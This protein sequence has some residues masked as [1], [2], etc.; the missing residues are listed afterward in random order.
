MGITLPKR[1][2]GAAPQ[3]LKE[4]RQITVIGANGAGKTRFSLKLISSFGNRAYVMSAMKAMFPTPAGRKP[5]EGSIDDLFAKADSASSFVKL[6]ANTE[7]ERL[8]FLLLHDEFIELMKYKSACFDPDTPAGK[9]AEVPHTKLDVLVSKWEEV[10]PN[11]RILRQGGKLL[12]SSASG[13]DVY[14]T[15]RLSDGEKAILYYLGAVQYAMPGAMIL[16]DDPGAFIHRSIMQSLWN[17]IEQM[18]PDCTFVYNTHD[19]DFASSRLDNTCIWVKSYDALNEAWDY[20]IVGSNQGLSEE[21]YIDLLGSRKPVLFIEG[22]DTHSI[23]SKLYPLVFTEYTVK[24][25]GSCNQVIEATRSFNDLNGF[26]HLDSYGI[27]DRDRRSDKEV[28][29][30]RA[31]KILVPDVAEIENLLLLPGIIS[32]VAR[33]RGKN[34]GEVLAKVKK[35]ILGMFEREL[36][37]QAML[38]VRHYVKKTVEVRIDKKFSN[39]NALEDHMLDLVNEINPRGMYES[40]CREF[41]GYIDQNDYLSVLKV[42]NQKQMLPDCN[43]AQLCGLENKDRYLRYVLGVLKEDGPDATE[44]R[45]AVKR[46]FGIE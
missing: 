19:I 45:N 42:Y 41:H 28:G 10:F 12:F 35:S 9:K 27:V 40:L 38:H 16:V 6:D 15:L 36:R 25:L 21:L 44:I 2:D 24:P 43:V 30:L 1:I 17:V 3:Q 14:S 8:T 13:N 32:V 26:H 37:S 18:R 39:I 11:N 22:D 5:L 34:P 23:D 46:C 29:Y 20:E 7:L 31:K 33:R 4:G